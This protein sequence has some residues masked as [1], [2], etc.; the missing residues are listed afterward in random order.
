M[1]DS[2]RPHR[3][4]PSRLRHPWDSPGKNTGVGCQAATGILQTDVEQKKST[5]RQT[6]GPIP[7]EVHKHTRRTDWPMPP[8]TG[9][10]LLGG[11]CL[12]RGQGRAP[13]AWGRS[14]SKSGH[15]GYMHVQ[16]V[17]ICQAAK[18]GY[19]ILHTVKCALHGWN[20]GEPL[21]SATGSSINGCCL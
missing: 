14:L 18:D 7:R 1:S 13:G 5:E 17:K 20:R 15:T 19:S 3:R 21:H 8:R 6:L 2:V 4:Q 10:G 12:K 11:K 9:M 16:S